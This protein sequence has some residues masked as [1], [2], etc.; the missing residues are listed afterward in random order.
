VKRAAVLVTC[1]ILTGCGSSSTAPEFLL[2]GP[3]P[4]VYTGTVV[5]SAKGTG[6]VTVSI[7]SVGGLMSGT[8]DMSFGGKADQEYVSG[9]VSSG[10]YT[11]RFEECPSTETTSC[12]PDCT[13]AFSGSLTSSSLTGAYQAVPDVRCLSRTGTI[14]ATR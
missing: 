9:T 4:T 6:T 3:A 13:L 1:F 7:V 10:V 11:A 2:P 12:S 5:D 14:T 8:C